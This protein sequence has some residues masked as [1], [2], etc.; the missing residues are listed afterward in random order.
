MHPKRR[1][2]SR[3]YNKR[4]HDNQCAY[5]HGKQ[6]SGTI[7]DIIAAEIKATVCATVGKL[8]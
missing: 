5:A 6:R 8:P 7:A 4:Q 3:I 1:V 2:E